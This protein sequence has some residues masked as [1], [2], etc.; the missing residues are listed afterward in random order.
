MQV[1]GVLPNTGRLQSPWCSYWTTWPILYDFWGP[2]RKSSAGTWHVSS[3]KKMWF[4][5]GLV[6]LSLSLLL[7]FHAFSLSLSLFLSLSLSLTL[8]LS[9]YLSIYLSSYLS[10]YLS[11]SPPP[12]IKI[13]R[14]DLLSLMIL[15]PGLENSGVGIATE[16]VVNPQ[17]QATLALQLVTSPHL[18]CRPRPLHRALRTSWTCKSGGEQRHLGQL[19]LNM[20][21]TWME[22]LQLW[23][24]TTMGI[25]PTYLSGI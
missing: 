2:S 19:S 6:S 3:T 17:S 5:T 14:K 11:L 4:S 8:S 12:S 24:T 22:P 13:S 25:L 16:P 20:D 21:V 15:L 7:F 10:L 18:W 23:D 1:S 9:I